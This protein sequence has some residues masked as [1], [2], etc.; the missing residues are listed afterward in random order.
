MKNYL[1]GNYAF[2]CDTLTICWPLKPLV[3]SNCIPKN[4]PIIRSSFPGDVHV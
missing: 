2:V 1:A 4:A 3:S